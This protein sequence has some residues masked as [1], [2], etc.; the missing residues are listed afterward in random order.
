VTLSASRSKR[1]KQ[2]ALAAGS[3]AAHV[4]VLGLL[5]LP[6]SPLFADRSND[7]D[8]LTVTLERPSRSQVPPDLAATPRRAAPSAIQP[9]APR[10]PVP[11]SV[12]PLPYDRN[13]GIGT[14][15][16]PAPLPEG[17][18]GDVR[19]ALRGSGV[20][21]A[22]AAAVGLNRRERERCDER[23][24]EAARRA[25]QYAEAPMD[26]RKRA[27]FDQIAAGQA[28]YQRYRDAPMGPGVDHRSR[29]GPGKA[30]DIPFVMG[31]T[32]GIGRKKSDQSLGITR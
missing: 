31:D 28:A 10:L 14:A 18:R 16:H 19:T 2:G 7:E 24:G 32:D 11:A 12:T 30:K 21:C 8:A 22:N 1:L 6:A 27:A 9:R 29:D 17:P 4:V 3:L 15:L 26:A 20:G 23:W 5:A 25:P 13:A